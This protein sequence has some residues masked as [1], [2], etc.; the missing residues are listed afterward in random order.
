MPPYGRFERR[1]HEFRPETVDSAA[2]R[3]ILFRRRI[4]GARRILRRAEHSQHDITAARNKR[5]GRIGRPCGTGFGAFR[6]GN[7]L[8]PGRSV[9]LTANRRG[10][11]TGIRSGRSGFRSHF[12]VRPRCSVGR[13]ARGLCGVRTGRRCR[14]SGRRTGIRS[15]RNRGRTVSRRRAGVCIRSRNT[16]WSAHLLRAFVIEL[17]ELISPE[18]EGDQETPQCRSTRPSRTCGRV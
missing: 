2:H 3:R 14:R 4:D 12:G 11:S 1:N 6:R 10:G 16:G 8:L 5:C 7:I 15:S 9:P 13:R 18:T 17:Q